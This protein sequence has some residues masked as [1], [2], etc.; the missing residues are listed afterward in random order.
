MQALPC[1]TSHWLPQGSQVKGSHHHKEA[2]LSLGLE[3]HTVKATSPV[4]SASMSSLATGGLCNQ[5]SLL[6][7]S[8]AGLVTPLGE[9]L[10][11][12]V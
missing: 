4:P 10:E 8:T 1:L 12:Q 5:A 2:L 7:D 6:E 11:P 9:L 3:V